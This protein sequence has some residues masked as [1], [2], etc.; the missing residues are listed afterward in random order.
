[1]FANTKL[2]AVSMAISNCYKI[3]SFKCIQVSKL[4]YIFVQLNM[5]KYE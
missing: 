5:N 2:V 4:N 3:F 1:M